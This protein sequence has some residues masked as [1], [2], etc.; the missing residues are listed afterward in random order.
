MRTIDF[1][2]AAIDLL[3]K[4]EYMKKRDRVDDIKISLKINTIPKVNIGFIKF[5]V[6]RESK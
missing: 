6:G 3:V 4:A 2:Q 5:V 1:E